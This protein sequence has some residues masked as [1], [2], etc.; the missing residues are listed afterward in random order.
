MPAIIPDP[1]AD[2]QKEA[3]FVRSLGYDPYEQG[4]KR[5]FNDAPWVDRPTF[6]DGLEKFHVERMA[7]TPPLARY[8]ESPPWVQYVLG[9][10]RELQQLLNLTPRQLAI[11]SSL[12]AYSSFRGFAR[13]PRPAA[14]KCRVLY[15]PSTDRGQLHFKNVDDPAP[16]NW[17][18]ERSRPPTLYASD[19][20]VWDGVGSGLHMDDEPEEIFPL[21]IPW[22]YR[23][24]ANDVPGAVQFL[25][26]YCFFYGGANFVL[27]DKQRRSVAIEKCSHNFIEVFPP[28][29]ASGFTHCSGMVCRNPESPQGRYQRAKREQYRR[30]YGLPA[31]GPDQVFWD[32]C[33]RA[34]R[35]LTESV[36]AMGPKPGFDDISRLFITPWPDGL[37]KNGPRLH[38]Q[39]TV[40]EYT[41]VSHVALLDERVYYRWQ[42]DEQLRFPE[43]PEVY[44]Y[45]TTNPTA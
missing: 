9:L 21:P 24:Y 3:A 31:D 2:A 6:L 45:P 34:E 37:N 26:R 43:Q 11:R 5:M 29:P 28:D 30:L 17:K 42:R 10:E 39:Q 18:P 35:K 20:L 41:L 4:M 12:G 1:R 38:P 8:P 40:L 14:E 15:V 16:P 33:D 44:D 32:A 22:M 13:G 7:R 36:R 19:D 27:H 25:T 23:Q